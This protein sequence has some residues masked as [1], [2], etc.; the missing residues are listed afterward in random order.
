MGYRLLLAVCAL[1]LVVGV[2]TTG[3]LPGGR[4]L[5]VRGFL[6]FFGA[7]IGLAVLSL[8][9]VVNTGDALRQIYFMLEGVAFIVFLVVWIVSDHWLERIGRAWLF[10]FVVNLLIGVWEASTGNHL[11]GSGMLRLDDAY[12][13]QLGRMPSAIFGNPNNFAFFL[14][15]TIPMVLAWWRYRVHGWKATALGAA[16]TVAV[17]AVVAT[18]SRLGIVGVITGIVCWWWLP[19][20]AGAARPRS[21]RWKILSLSVAV[22]IPFFFTD[23]AGNAWRELV[24]IP[25]DLTTGLADDARVQLTTGV[26]DVLRRTKGLGVGAGNIET[27][28]AEYPFSQNSG[29]TNP[30]GWWIEIAGN[31]GVLGV[32]GYTL[33]YLLLVRALWRAYKRQTRRGSD[34]TLLEGALAGLLAYP[35]VSFGPSSIAGVVFHWFFLGYCLAA[36]NNHRVCHR[37]TPNPVP[38]R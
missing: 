38:Q 32:I 30:H 16:G 1:I 23:V 34:R 33:C 12:I 31:Y 17:F 36:L 37:L 22:A 6:A 14:A 24:S 29:V 27:Y 5:R 3:R 11:P 35:V 20:L 13:E 7:W 25:S 26:I 2:A 4:D 21:R 10:V 15:L 8:C 9:W 19:W 28:L 18:R